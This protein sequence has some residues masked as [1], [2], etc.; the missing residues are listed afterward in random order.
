MISLKISL[1]VQL[2]TRVAYSG[3][4]TLKNFQKIKLID[5]NFIGI[6]A[7]VDRGLIQE[8]YN[9]FVSYIPII[10]ENTGVSK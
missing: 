7:Y 6:C 4:K 8:L 5:L 2:L 10:R 9:F 1:I 3:I